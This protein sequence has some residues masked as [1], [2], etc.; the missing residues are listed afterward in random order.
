[1]ASARDCKPLLMTVAAAGYNGTRHRQQVEQR[2]NP[3]ATVPCLPTAAVKQIDQGYGNYALV[4]SRSS[5]K[6]RHDVMIHPQP[7]IMTDDDDDDD[8]DEQWSRLHQLK[9]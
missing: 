8:D 9:N 4:F 6:A 3:A 2:Q 1:M 5:L 7:Y